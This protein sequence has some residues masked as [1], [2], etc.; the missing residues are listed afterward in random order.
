MEPA[1]RRF[2]RFDKEIYLAQPSEAGRLEILQIKTR[3]MRIAPAVDLAEVA[4]DTHGYVGADLSQVP[5][6]SSF[7]SPPS[8]SLTP[9]TSHTPPFPPPPP[10]VI[11]EAAFTAI[12]EVLPHL[13]ISAETL[14]P[15][16]S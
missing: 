13:D 9:S 2:G 6:P 4:R 15:T 16:R 8:L 11:M 12:R 10:Q 3:D 5:R 7:L 1:L 14:D